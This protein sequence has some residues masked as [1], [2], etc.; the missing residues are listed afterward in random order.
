MRSV[1]LSQTS[2]TQEVLIPA[3]PVRVFGALVDPVK[4]AEVTGSEATGTGKAGGKFTAW[5]GYIFGEY[6]KLEKGKEIVW[7]WTTTE[8][9]KGYP[10]STVDIKLSAARG[11]TKLVMVHTDVPASQAE[12]YR[13][14]W[15]DYY[16]DPL[17]KYFE[18]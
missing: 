5:D 2:I 16:W 10:A 11:G 8:W 1:K 14:G 9:P 13:Q 15:I 3:T 7:R 4:H 6:V 12:S 18:K 17:K